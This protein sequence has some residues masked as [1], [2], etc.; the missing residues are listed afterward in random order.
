MKNKQ[1]AVDW[2][3]E[4]LKIEFGFVFSNNILQQVKEM[5]KQQIV[6]AYNKAGAFKFGKEYYN[7]T[8]KQY[9]NK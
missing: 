7:E 3:T 2:L 6:T 5:E 4:K 1:T 9:G 8:F